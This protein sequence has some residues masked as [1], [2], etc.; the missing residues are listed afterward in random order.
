MLYSDFDFHYEGAKTL[1]KISKWLHPNRMTSVFLESNALPT[2][3][4]GRPSA[5]EGAGQ[6]Q[7]GEFGEIRY[8]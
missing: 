6:T 1:H 2:G 8:S 7:E 5:T 3:E 4:E